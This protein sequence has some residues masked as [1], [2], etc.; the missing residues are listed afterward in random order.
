MFVSFRFNP[1]S[2]HSGCA[3]SDSRAALHD[4]Y[5][6]G[7]RSLLFCFFF[8]VQRAQTAKN[9]T[10]IP[11]HISIHTLHQFH[12]GESSTPTIRNCS[13]SV[14][15]PNHKPSGT[16]RGHVLQPDGSWGPKGS[17]PVQGFVP[18]PPPS[19]PAPNSVAPN[20]STP[21]QSPFA[22]NSSQSAPSG[23]NTTPYTSYRPNPYAQ[24]PTP[25]SAPQSNVSQA[26]ASFSENEDSSSSEDE[27][28]TPRPNARTVEMGQ[29]WG[30]K[31]KKSKYEY[32]YEDR[33]QR[34]ELDHSNTAEP[35]VD[36][37]DVDDRG[38][39]LNPR[40]LLKFGISGTKDWTNKLMLVRCWK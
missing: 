25:F 37:I 35:Y 19:Q 40:G 20:W 17:V 22:T 16:P 18:L 9:S 39:S 10:F 33:F 3:I 28:E 26:A 29:E 8:H 1:S 21:F 2:L 34:V 11:L 7:G 13:N 38:Q 36:L 32:E 27:E 14:A 30:D 15:M 12:A 24:S 6:M 31:K 4:G 23:P 5:K